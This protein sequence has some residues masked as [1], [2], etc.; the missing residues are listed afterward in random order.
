[1]S[2]ENILM[3]IVIGTYENH[4]LGYKLETDN[5][6]FILK[7]SF[8]TEVHS[9][10]VKC[11]ASSDKFLASG[12]VDE[13]I[14]LF[15]ME[16]RKIIGALFQHNAAVKMAIF[17]F[18]LQIIGN[19]SKHCRGHKD[20]INSIAVHPTGKMAVSV[21][22]DK[23]L[24]TWNLIKGRSAYI[25]NINKVADIIRWSPDGSK[26]A[27]SSNKTVDIYSV[28]KAAL[29][30]T[31]DFQHSVCDFTFITNDLLAVGGK[32]EYIRFYNLVDEVMCFELK[33]KSER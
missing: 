33:A 16:S 2:S 9:Q 24:R 20:A 14:Q 4:L 28:E 15:N 11:I 32:S 21:G 8:T 30:S 19:A 17:V 1:M 31:I 23:S 3:E 25:T 27:I 29:I 5:D 6:K 10:S 22:K 7:L 18:G 12:S 13:T 26:F